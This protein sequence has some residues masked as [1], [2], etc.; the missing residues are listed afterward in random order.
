VDW[1]IDV[2]LSAGNDVVM[3]LVLALEGQSDD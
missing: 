3:S 2:P 1:Y